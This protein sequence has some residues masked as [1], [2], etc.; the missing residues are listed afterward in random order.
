MNKSCQTILSE[1]F[2]LNI[3]ERILF[4]RILFFHADLF[5]LM[6]FLA[7]TGIDLS[8]WWNLNSFPNYFRGGK[9][10]ISCT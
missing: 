1:N 2:L 9:M 5:L 7:L 3:P 10:L 8:E 4:S 6:K